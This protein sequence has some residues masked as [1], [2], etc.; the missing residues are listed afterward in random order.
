MNVS[1]RSRILIVAAGCLLVAS[2]A[3]YV[4]FFRSSDEERIRA[5]IVELA[6]IVSVKEA[7]TVLSRAARVRGGMKNLVDTE[8]RVNIAELGLDIRGL[9]SFEEDAIKAGLMYQSADCEF[10]SVTIKI[11]ES[12]TTA[13]AD[14]VALV[15]AN[16]GG[17]RKAD[18]RDVHFLLRKDGDWKITTIDVAPKKPD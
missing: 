5:V 4:S 14:A 8:V 12:R 3:L 13:T 11:D 6:R 7:D 16:R 17:E 9:R 10:A 1:S 15:T 18:R 2:V